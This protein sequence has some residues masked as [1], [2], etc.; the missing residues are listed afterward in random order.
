M[1]DFWISFQ[2][3]Q[4]GSSRVVP[5]KIVLSMQPGKHSFAEAKTELPGAATTVKTRWL[6]SRKTV[7][8]FWSWTGTSRNAVYKTSISFLASACSCGANSCIDAHRTTLRKDSATARSK[9][10]STSI[11]ARDTSSTALNA[12]S[13]CVEG[14]HE[15]YSILESCSKADLERGWNLG[16]SL[17]QCRMR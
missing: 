10:S 13:F 3:D 15:G 5:P 11:L 9:R 16:A 1:C 4:K 17:V 7:K 14:S 2:I 12:W 8:S 6:C